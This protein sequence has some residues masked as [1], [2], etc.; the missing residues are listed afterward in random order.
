MR[1]ARYLL[2]LVAWLP[3][4]ARAEEA[5]KSPQCTLRSDDDGDDPPPLD[6]DT[7]EPIVLDEIG[8]LPRRWAE[9][10]AGLGTLLTSTDQVHINTS[11]VIDVVPFIPKRAQW[12][13]LG[14]YGAIGGGHW[15]SLDHGGFTVEA[16]GRLRLVVEPND[17]VE[18]YV[19][20]GGGMLYGTD[21]G[22]RFGGNGHLGLGIK[23]GQAA[24]VEATATSLFADTG[25]T[26]TGYAPALGGLIGFDFCV[27]TGFCEYAAPEPRYVNQTCRLYREAHAACPALRQTRVC[28]AVARALDTYENG[29]AGQDEVT[30]FIATAQRWAAANGD[31]VLDTALQKLAASHAAQREWLAQGRYAVRRALTQERAAAVIRSYAPYPIDLAH[32]LGCMGNATCQATC[33]P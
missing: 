7:C 17:I 14:A 9:A 20:L 3:A 15:S 32:A 19:V 31:T 26:Q 18:P 21:D 4:G 2:L 13:K 23:L 12:F 25:R 5:P 27:L 22:G 11:F 8:I 16:G 29:A 28:A 1:R 10:S 24:F 6:P 33:A 30:A